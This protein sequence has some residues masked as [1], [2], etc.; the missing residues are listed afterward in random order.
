MLK[1]DREIEPVVESPECTLG[2][3]APWP[4]M[5]REIEPEME[6]Q[7]CTLGTAVPWH[8]KDLEIE[9]KVE[10]P[11]G[12]LGTAS[13]WHT[14][15][16]GIEPEAESLECTLGTAAAKKAAKTARRKAAKASKKQKLPELIEL[17]TL[18]VTV[19]D[20]CTWCQ[21]G[22]LWHED[23]ED[24]HTTQSLVMHYTCSRCKAVEAD[25]QRI[26]KLV[27][28]EQYAAVMHMEFSD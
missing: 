5:E 10:S 14:K 25:M 3:A 20:E 12:T 7:G 6:S 9:P 16:L 26:K 8:M 13:P 4:R 15:N 22:L 28:E 17:L 24:G 2:K 18:H 11:E 23:D 21:L 1:T 27:P 19:I